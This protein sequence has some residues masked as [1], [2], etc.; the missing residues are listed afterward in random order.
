MP[1]ITQ[2][3]TTYGSLKFVLICVI[4]GNNTVLIFNKLQ[5][6]MAMV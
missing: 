6:V 2:I 4:R 3:K 5:L 1:L